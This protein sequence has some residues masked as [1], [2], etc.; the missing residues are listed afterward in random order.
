MSNDELTYE[1][2]MEKKRQRK[3]WNEKE[4]HELAPYA[5]MG[6]LS[7]PEQ[8]GEMRNP[9][10]QICWMPWNTA[11][12]CF[13]SWIFGS[14]KDCKEWICFQTENDSAI[15]VMVKIKEYEEEK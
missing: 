5:L 3:N 15:A 4:V 14:R 8:E 11:E 6:L 10:E 13:E 1:Q 9:K 2:I 7:N 12:N